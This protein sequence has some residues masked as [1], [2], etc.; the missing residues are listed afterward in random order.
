MAAYQAGTHQIVIKRHGLW[1]SDTFW[2][3]V[4]SVCVTSSPVAAAL[5]VTMDSVLFVVP[6]VHMLQAS[7]PV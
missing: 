5:S 3:Y 2:L 7:V 1:V 6:D 4:T